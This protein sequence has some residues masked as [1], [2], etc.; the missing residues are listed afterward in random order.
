MHLEQ[1]R[2]LRLSLL[3]GVVDRDK[4]EQVAAILEGQRAFFN[5]VS[6]GQGTANSRILDYLG[7]GKTDKAVFTS[8]LPTEASLEL[9]DK[10]DDKLELNKPG[11]GIAFI[12]NVHQGC[13]HKPVSFTGESETGGKEMEN[14]PTT[15]DLIIVILNRGYTEEVMDEARAAGATGGTVLHARGCGLTGAEK[16]FGVTIQHEK[17]M[18]LVLAPVD[19]SCAI[20]AAIADKVGPGTDANA[21]SFSM[22]VN[23]VRG[24]AA[25]AANNA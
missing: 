14:R 16:F 11:H 20:M 12:T 18:M 5:L 10:L 3:V 24:L 19:T 6:L 21:I 7:L 15:H 2:E 1:H 23:G 8:I 25:Q 4:A 13:Y 9:L 22:P 17:E